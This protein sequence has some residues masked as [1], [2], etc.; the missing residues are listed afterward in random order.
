MITISNENNCSDCGHNNTANDKNDSN[1]DSNVRKTDVTK[2]KQQKQGYECINRVNNAFSFFRSYT[3]QH[4]L[5]GPIFN[6]PF[7]FSQRLSAS[8]LSFLRLSF[9]CL[10]RIIIVLH[11]VMSA[12]T[13]LPD[14]ATQETLSLDITASN[15]I[16]HNYCQK[17]GINRFAMY[18]RQ[19]HENHLIM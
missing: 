11:S 13:R 2:T 8:V 5:L 15:K 14:V 3:K 18:P 12:L 16:F 19:G 7:C 10:S 1:D 6:L 4:S 17:Q 9:L